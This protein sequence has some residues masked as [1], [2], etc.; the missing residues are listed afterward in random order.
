MDSGALSG[1]ALLYRNT[2]CLSVGVEIAWFEAESISDL[3][4]TGLNSLSSIRHAAVLDNGNVAKSGAVTV[5]RL[6]RRCR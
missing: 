5:C 3:M 2:A 1:R 4:D 6:D